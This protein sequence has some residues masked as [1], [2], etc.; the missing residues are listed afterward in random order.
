V[1]P[2]I[3]VIQ[4]YWDF[5]EATAPFDLRAD[6]R[7]LLDEAIR[8]IGNDV[9]VTV[10]GLITSAEDAV[11]LAARCANVDAIIV[12]TTMAAPS[13]TSMEL[14]DRLPRTP[15]VVWALSQRSGLAED[16]AH[17]DITT[18]GSTVGAPMVASALARAGRVFD[19]VLTTLAE[20]RA[21]MDAARQAAA[22][23]RLRRTT[24]L[25]IGTPIAGYTSVDA[26]D[27]DL[28]ELGV[29]TVR[30]PP[31]E[32]AARSRGVSID[33]VNMLKEQIYSEFDVDPLVSGEALERS[34]R[35]EAVL[36]ELLAEHHAEAG[37]LNCHGPALRF[38]EEIG[39]APCLALGRL[40]TRGIP[41]SCTGD[42]V[43]A[44]AMLTVQ[45]LGHATLYHEIEAVDHDSDE[46]LLANTGEHDLRLCGPTRPRLVPDVWYEDDNMTGPCA[47]FSLPEGPASLVGFALAGG[48]RW[49]VAEGRFTGRS[50]I[51]TGTPN[52]AFRFASGHV[53]EAWSRWASTGVTHHSAA[54]NA[55]VA[56]DIQS[57]AHH[58]AATAIVV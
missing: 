58:L 38:G 43:T 47:L 44:I 53:R 1:R 9:H 41:W 35:V 49:V 34:V 32:V 5:W 20:P 50:A 8:A 45:A 24:L 13:A 12:L 37:T 4:P 54:T 29:T 30:I 42:V 6:R 28:R 52:G 22:A 39:I 2:S 31:E 23:G 27:E 26:T 25:K 56:A 46:V 17:S 55:L 3:A 15:V 11:E 33:S 48:P 10:S 36:A 14:I 18:Q 57:V 16:F 51:R 19:V 40:T 7:R 21:A